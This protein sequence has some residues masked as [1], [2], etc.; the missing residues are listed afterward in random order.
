M[1]RPTP[2]SKGGRIWEISL[3]VT[4]ITSP[5]EDSGLFDGGFLVREVRRNTG[6]W[7]IF[8]VRI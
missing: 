2:G 6:I 1:N 8:K 7:D 3:E 5:R 4:A